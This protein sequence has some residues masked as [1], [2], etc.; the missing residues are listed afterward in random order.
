MPTF[1]S[2][3]FDSCKPPVHHFLVH[4]S[5]SWQEKG[6]LFVERMCCEV[7]GADASKDFFK[8]KLLTFAM[9]LQYGAEVSKKVSRKDVP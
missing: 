6:V 7:S 9:Q 1:L 3:G 4:L 8:E 5:P 2:S